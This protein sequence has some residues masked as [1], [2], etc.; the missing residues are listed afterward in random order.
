MRISDWSSDVCSSDR[1]LAVAL[2]LYLLEI[3]W[4]KPEPLIISKNCAG[5]A[6]HQTGIKLVCKRCHDRRILM[7]LGQTNMP[8]HGSCALKQ[9]FES[10]TAQRP[11]CRKTNEIPQGNTSPQIFRSEKRLGG[12][13]E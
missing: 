4:Q 10:L 1:A 5:L 7:A 13:E 9:T 6:L 11:G 3:G 8:V 12:E 2:H